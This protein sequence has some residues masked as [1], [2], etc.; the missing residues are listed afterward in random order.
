MKRPGIFGALPALVWLAAAGAVSAGEM[1]PGMAAAARTAATDDVRV[2]LQPPP[3][4][5][6]SPLT[7][8]FAMR[9]SYFKPAMDTAIRYDTS[10]LVQGTPISAEDTLGMD[11]NMNLATLE[12]VFRLTPRQR[13]RADYLKISRKGDAVLD[14]PLVF[15]EDTFLPGDR[16]ESS[17]DMRL[18]NLTYTYSIFRHERWELALGMGLHL[19]Q[20]QGEAEVPARFLGDEFSVAGPF[21]S[22]ALEGTVLITTRF[23]FNAR[24]QY[25]TGNS[26]SVDGS[27]AHYHAD[28]QFRAWPNVAF[29]LGYTSYSIRVDSTDEDFSGRFV[30]KAK[31]PEAFVRVSF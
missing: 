31:G 23:S 25:L 20:A 7:D 12:L 15:G 19:L 29:G 10:P 17:L 16:V 8:R 11:D 26:S 9:G 24:A 21:P 14:A 2:L 6:Y 4:V 1:A 5:Q 27:Y 30:L 3:E 22:L 18:L 28:V 13:L